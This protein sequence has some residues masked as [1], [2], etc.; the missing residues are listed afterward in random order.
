[1]KKLLWGISCVLLALIWTISVQA[2]A[3]LYFRPAVRGSVEYN[4]NIFLEDK[5]KTDDMIYTLGMGLRTELL[6]QTAGIILDYSP[7]YSWYHDEDNLDEWRHLADASIY[8]D[9]S[10]RTRLDI[11]N[12]YLRTTR[13]TDSSD[14]LNPDNPIEG[15]Q[16]EADTNRRGRETYYTNV[17]TGRLGHQFGDRDSI[18][19]AFEY[20]RLR[21]LERTAQ[22]D[23]DRNDASENDIYTPSVGME[24][25][26]SN[27]WGVSLDGEYSYRGLQDA[28]DR[29]I[30]TG[31]FRL[32]R[33]FTR[34]LDGFA[35]YS[36]KY[37]DFNNEDSNSDY[38]VYEPSIGIRWQLEKNAF[39]RL[40][41]GY[42][43]Q[44]KDD[45]DDP[46]IDDS[47]ESGILID[48]EVFRRWEWRRGNIDMRALSGY[49]QDDTGAEDNGFNIYYDASLRGRYAFLKRLSG[50]AF[51]GYRWSSYPD[52]EQARTDQTFQA[53]A[54]LEWSPLKW[55]FW[56]L[57]YN[58]RNRESNRGE[59]E[60]TENRVIL[61]LTLTPEQA[62]R[63][64]D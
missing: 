17:A 48:S 39:V 9:F 12:T 51:A 58:F 23:S 49:R 10:R 6:W 38:Q 11:R 50:S 36:H 43:Y 24:Y 15:R 32:M 61:S 60:Y 54:G 64:F 2:A 20:R 30:Y 26:F 41:V 4:D 21:Q 28:D 16:I 33:N 56:N 27:W 18:Y 29:E 19:A 25:W 47:S 14:E 13:P 5:N 34:H 8:K 35:A 40:G 22:N 44:D 7:S 55:M 1:M 3:Q 52:Q 42:Y 63:L 53:G 46:L 57:D 37:V 31:T 62:W 59:D 45:S